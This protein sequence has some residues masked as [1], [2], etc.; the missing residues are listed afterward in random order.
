MLLELNQTA[1]ADAHKLLCLLYMHKSTNTDAALVAFL[2]QREVERLQHAL[3]DA[4]KLLDSTSQPV[5]YI[6][7]CILV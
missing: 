1:L 7:N 6:S 2:V 3:A 5:C 4:N